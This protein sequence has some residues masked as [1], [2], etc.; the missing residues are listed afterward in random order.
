[1][2]DT[3]MI[4]CIRE[5]PNVIREI[6]KNKDT[7]LEPIINHFKKHNV[8]R[9]YFSG[10]GSPYNVGATLRPMMQNMLDIEVSVD[11][12][13]FFNK[14]L[15]FNANK[16][17]K[18]DEMLLIC[19]AQSGKTKGPVDAAVKARSIGIPVLSLTLAEDGILAKNSDIVIKKNSGEERSFPETKGHVASLM[20]LA[21]A[22]VEIAHMLNK[23]DN[24]KYD[25]YMKV[26]FEM[27]DR[28]EEI[29]S[30]SEKWYSKYKEKLLT[31]PYLTFIGFGENYH[32][33]VEGSLK[34]LETTLKP[35]LSY[36]CEEYMH[37]QNQP[38][39]SQSVIFMIASEGNELNRIHDLAKWCRLKGAYVIVI[40]NDNDDTLTDDDISIPSHNCAYLDAIEYLIPFQVFGHYIADDMNLSCVVAHHDD[41]G[42][43]LG[44]RYE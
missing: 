7:Y 28:V 30:R 3:A 39:D 10:H 19:P 5:E 38:V 25:S 9:I 21:L 22:T 24:N 20:I 6:I 17:Y 12:A 41:A 40:G 26:F 11:Y 8:K 2:I 27:P 32:T 33:A 36:E 29:I 14:N 37:G 18:N 15:D 35:C 43:E 31:A 34:I 13:S 16:I 23:I 44:V 42:K 1:M 4:E